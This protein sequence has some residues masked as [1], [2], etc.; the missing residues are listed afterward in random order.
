MT[1]RY[2]RLFMYYYTIVGVS[3]SELLM[4]ENGRMSLESINTLFDAM[5]VDT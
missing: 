2:D 3:L 5:S 1:R 4:I